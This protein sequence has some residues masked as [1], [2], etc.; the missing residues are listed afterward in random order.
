MDLK[1]AHFSV[2]LG[3]LTVLH[4][5]AQWIPKL[6]MYQHFLFQLKVTIKGFN[7]DI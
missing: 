5:F 7:V 4:I 3:K 2:G 6:K 1:F